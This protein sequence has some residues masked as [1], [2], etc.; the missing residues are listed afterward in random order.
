[1]EL[2]MVVPRFFRTLSRRIAPVAL[3]MMLAACGPSKPVFQGSDISG[4][5]LGHGLALTDDNGQPRTLKDYDGKVKLVFFG[6]TQCPDVCPTSLAGLADVMKKLGSDAD[7][8]QVLMISVDPERDTP[9]V[10]KQ[11]VNTFDPRFMGLRGT[12]EQT[13]QAAQSFKAYYAK[14]PTTD[15]KS[16]SVDHS[17]VFYLMDRTGAPRVLASN[18]IGTDALVHDIRAL[19]N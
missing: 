18:T 8:V 2:N 10:L 16:Y 4:T 6:Y 9:A 1:M 12:D 13:K 11:Y 17:S 3:L 15:G 19:L 14:E 7:Q 5:D